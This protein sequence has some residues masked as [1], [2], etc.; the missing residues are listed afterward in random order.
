M[1]AVRTP[2]LQTLKFHSRGLELANECHVSRYEY[3]GI[4]I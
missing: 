4:E 1:E 2:L 3:G